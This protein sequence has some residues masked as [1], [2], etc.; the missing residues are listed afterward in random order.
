VNDAERDAMISPA[1]LQR[2]LGCGRTT[3]YKLLET[4]TIRSYRVA[5]LIRIRRSDVIA[6]LEQNP[7]RPDAYGE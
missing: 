4:G 5:R 1:E 6:F 7:Y 2:L 3:T